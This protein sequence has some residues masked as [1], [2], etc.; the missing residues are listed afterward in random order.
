MNHSYKYGISCAPELLYNKNDWHDQSVELEELVSVSSHHRDEFEILGCLYDRAAINRNM[1]IDLAGPSQAAIENVSKN[2]RYVNSF[3]KNSNPVYV[4]KI[5]RAVI[6]N[7]MVFVELNDSIVPLY[8]NFRRL[9]RVE[10]GSNIAS[11]LMN[12]NEMKLI[13]VADSEIMFFGSMGSFNYGH[14]LTDDFG[15]YAALL[16]P[17]LANSSINC[18][19]SKLGNDIDKIRVE[20]VGLV[21]GDSN[22]A[23]IFIDPETPVRVHN[24]LYTTPCS[25]H[26]FLKN[27]H[28]LEFIKKVGTQN[29]NVADNS[30]RIFVN[31]AQSWPRRIR[32]YDKIS[33]LLARYGFKEFIPDG[34]SLKNQVDVFSSA[35]VIVGIMGAAMANMAFC[36]ARTP[37]LCLAP[38]GW[39]EPYFWDQAAMCNHSYSALFGRPVP[40][41]M[42]Q[43]IHQRSFDLSPIILAHYLHQ[44]IKS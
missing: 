39:P 8:E 22:P 36:Q 2:F 7:N 41:D 30:M 25:D 44:I 4:V 32:N 3:Y 21:T 13:E 10:K 23:P 14:W 29:K 9:D 1:P 15:R 37:I 31:R 11:K 5:R 6:W 35:G 19:F 38:D 18:L 28:A 16:M 12:A 40:E 27:P 42:E 17:R 26:P 24:L 43:S 34:L 20:G 33:P